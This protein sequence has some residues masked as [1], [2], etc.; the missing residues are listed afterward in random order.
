MKWLKDR[1]KERSTWR[2]LAVLGMVAGVNIDP[3]QVEAIVTG[4]GAIVA[5]TETLFA[6]PKA[7]E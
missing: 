1:M 3:T 2:G 7:A 6:E 4:A 5:V